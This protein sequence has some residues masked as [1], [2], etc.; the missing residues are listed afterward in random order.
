MGEI[1]ITTNASNENKGADAKVGEIIKEFKA[2]R[3][4][5]QIKRTK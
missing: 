1:K 2:G 5:V 3:L 4:H